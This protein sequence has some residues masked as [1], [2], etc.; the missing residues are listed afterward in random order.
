M[1]DFDKIFLKVGVRDACGGK[2]W[3]LFANRTHLQDVVQLLLHLQ[4]LVENALVYVLQQASSVAKLLDDVKLPMRG[5]LFIGQLVCLDR[6][7]V[8]GIRVDL[9]YNT[10]TTDAHINS[11]SDELSLCFEK[12]LHLGYCIGNIDVRTKH[13]FISMCPDRHSRNG[14]K[15]KLT[16]LRAVQF[17]VNAILKVRKV[18]MH[19]FEPLQPEN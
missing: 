16:N 2:T 13:T 6:A 9:Q 8:V 10:H 19:F 7:K 5:V 11:E 3:H 1:Q 17:K 12:G 18:H 4:R 14:L 15:T